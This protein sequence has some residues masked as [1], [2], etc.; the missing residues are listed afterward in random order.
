MLLWNYIP[1]DYS[2]LQASIG[3][4]SILEFVSTMPLPHPQT[5]FFHSP[6][7][8]HIVVLVLHNSLNHTH[9]HEG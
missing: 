1:F 6:L 9:I 5:I 3:L 8:S 7:V 4:V 2:F